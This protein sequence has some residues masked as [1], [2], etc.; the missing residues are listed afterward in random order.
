M[1]EF[2][3]FSRKGRTDGNFRTLRDAGFLDTVHQCIL[4]SIFKSHGHRKDVVFHAILGGPPNPP[5]HLEIRGD[6]LQ[7]ASIDERSWEKILKNVLKG[8]S[9]PGITVKSGSLQS[10]IKEKAEQGGQIFVLEEKG[11]DISEVK[12]DEHCVFVLGDHIG[13]PKKDEGFVLRHGEKLSLGKE[14]YLAASCIDIVNFHID[15]VRVRN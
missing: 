7:D 11:A 14:K 5:K 1:R 13:I 8:K 15:R 3:L 4:T 2:I 12:F 10:L 6:E 9:H